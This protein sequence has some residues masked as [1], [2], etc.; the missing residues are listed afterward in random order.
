MQRNSQ[1]RRDLDRIHLDP[2]ELIQ[3]PS[4]PDDLVKKIN[5]RRDFV[6]EE[7]EEVDRQFAEVVKA[8]RE[9]SCAKFAARTS[10][11]Q[12]HETEDA[13]ADAGEVF[14]S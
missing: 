4:L 11:R 3:L 7:L 12:T 10:H 13:S 14:P 1:A 6:G 2:E 5:L 9:A 8:V